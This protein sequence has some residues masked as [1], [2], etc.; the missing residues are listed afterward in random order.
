MAEDGEPAKK[1]KDFTDVVSALVSFFALY[2]RVNF[3]ATS[4]LR[5]KVKVKIPEII[6]AVKNKSQV[7]QAV[8]ELLSLEKKT[9]LAADQPSTVK[10][11]AA[12]LAVNH[13]CICKNSANN[14]MLCLFSLAPERVW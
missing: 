8:E 10:I 13:S 7:G 1:I 2:I 9:R 12:L 4:P 14:S 6:G 3:F 11:V 5:F